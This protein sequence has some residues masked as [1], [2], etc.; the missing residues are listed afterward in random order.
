MKKIVVLM[1]SMILLSGCDYEDGEVDYS[2]KV[3][4]FAGKQF[5]LITDR[6][7]G[8][9]YIDNTF[10]CNRGA[11]FAHVYTPY[12]SENGKLCKYYDGKIVEVGE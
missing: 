6:S 12:Y 11:D 8:I 10:Y 3:N 7:T 4:E 1:L 5:S 2:P 9:L